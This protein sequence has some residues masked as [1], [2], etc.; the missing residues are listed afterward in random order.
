[1]SKN[2]CIWEACRSMVKTRWAPA[3][4]IKLA[5]SF[6]EIGTRGRS[7]LSERAYPKYG[8]TAVTR[9]ADARMKASHIINS[10]IR[11]RSDGGQVGWTIKTSWP[12][13]F[14]PIWKLNSPSEKR[15]VLAFPS[16]QSRWPQI[17][18]ASSRCA[19]PEKTLIFPVTLIY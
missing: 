9:S 19:L 7:F 4:V 2:P 16:S 18:S 17:S 10:S 14:S 15:S 11:C 3:L 1:M 12:R 5:T 8:I 13:T 6:A